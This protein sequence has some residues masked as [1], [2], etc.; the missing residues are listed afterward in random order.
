[1]SVRG[2]L[3]DYGGVL[4]TATRLSIDDWTRR[5]GIDPQSF[6]RVLK[7]W[8]SRSAPPDNPLHRLE[9]GRL[10]AAEFNAVLTRELRSVDGGPVPEA[11]HLGGIFATMHL[12]PRMVALVRALRARGLRLGVLSNSWGNHYDPDLL[13]L[14]D[15]AVI[16]SEVGLRK[17]QPEIYELALE[18]LGLPAPEVVLVDDGEPNLEAA[19]LL[20]IHTVLHTDPQSTT[21]L[22]NRLIP[23]RSIPSTQKE[24][25]S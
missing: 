11:D 8:L 5:E 4:T 21:D 18:R 12:E 19:A 14:F 7:A 22:L 9:D 13:A 2:V 15:M 3:F 6:S 25:D 23:E 1:M 16:S 24:H 20:G 10:S 17:P